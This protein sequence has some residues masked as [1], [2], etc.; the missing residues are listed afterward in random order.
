MM[1]WTALENWKK[2]TAQQQTGLDLNISEGNIVVVR[3]NSPGMA[4]SPPGGHIRNQ[5]KAKK[6][7][8][9]KIA[10]INARY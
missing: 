1:D 4:F 7:T 8:Y 5:F 2:Q 10:S 6:K 9:R 3:L